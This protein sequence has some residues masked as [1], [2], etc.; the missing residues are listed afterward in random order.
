MSLVSVP[1]VLLMAAAVTVLTVATALPTLR[2]RER[3]S[4]LTPGRSL[5]RIVA[6]VMVVVLAAGALVLLRRRGLVTGGPEAETS[7]DP[8]LAAGPALAGFAAAI[9]MIRLYPWPVRLIAWA[10]ARRRHA[11]PF[12]GAK[13]LMLQPPAARLQLLVIILAVAVSVLSS[14]LGYSIEEGRRLSTWH[15]VGADYRVTTPGGL[16]D[17]DA[18]AGPE[19][20]EAVA[21]GVRIGSVAPRSSTM[22]VPERVAFLALAVDDFERVASGTP[23]DPQL[24]ESPVAT[25]PLADIGTAANPIEVLASAEWAGAEPPVVGASFS[26]LIGARRTTFVVSSIR[27]DFPSMDTEEPFVVASLASLNAAGSGLRPTDA[28]LRGAAGAD[29]IIEDSL[30]IG[31]NL[32]SRRQLFAAADDDP[33]SAGLRRAFTGAAALAIGFALLAAFSGPAMAAA[34][35]RAFLGYLRTMGLSRRQAL[36]LAAIEYLVPVMLATAAGMVLGIGSAVVFQ[37]GIRIESFSGGAL[38]AAVL[39]DPGSI[40]TLGATLVGGAVLA[41]GVYGL[42]GRRAELGGILR[43]GDE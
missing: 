8:L 41:A 42:V 28:F 1:A 25:Q 40:L 19:L 5:R 22:S 14:V 39:V 11:V 15:E 4:A 37:P 27:D 29:S 13:R 31:S 32:I 38:P 30:V 9:V 12:L 6:E 34:N 43:V 17:F 23:A 18:V 33:F 26:M 2:R 10:A 35:R 21:L 24:A 3:P 20:I 7:F 36:A 16:P